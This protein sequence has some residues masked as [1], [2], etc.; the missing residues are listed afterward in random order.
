MSVA[1]PFTISRLPY[2]NHVFRLPHD[3]QY[4]DGEELE[5]TLTNAFLALL[6]LGISTIRHA[7]DYPIGKPSYNV[8]FTLE[9]IHLIPRRYETYRLPDAGD[10]ISVNALGFAGLLLVLAD[11]ALENVKAHGVGKIL[12]GVALDSVHEL[13]LAGTTDEAV[14][15]AKV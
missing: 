3:L 6:D 14:D 2:A 12:K 4:K 15:I 5:R 13:Q 7:S 10:V 1:K 8:V 9:H 11:E